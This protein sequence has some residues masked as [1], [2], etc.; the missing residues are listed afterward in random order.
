MQIPEPPPDMIA[1]GDYARIMSVEKKPDSQEKKEV[2]ETKAS[3]KESAWRTG[4]GSLWY[5]LANVPK[6]A[7]SFDYGFKLSAKVLLNDGLTLEV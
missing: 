5:D 1:E 4:P 6:T 3:E 2:K 7:L